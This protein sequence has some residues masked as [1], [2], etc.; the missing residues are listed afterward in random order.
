[1]KQ[2]SARIG[3]MSRLYCRRSAAGAE[4]ATAKVSTAVSQRPILVMADDSVCALEDGDCGRDYEGFYQ[5]WR[6][7][8][9]YGFDNRPSNDFSRISQCSTGTQEREDSAFAT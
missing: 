8:A 1:M 6:P 3:R 2:F 9:A 5:K 4:A 7:K